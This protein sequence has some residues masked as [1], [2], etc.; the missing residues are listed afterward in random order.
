MN[1]DTFEGK[2]GQAMGLQGLTLRG[3]CRA[4]D[5]DPS[6][7]SKVLAGKRSPPWDEAVLRRLA[8]VLQ[9]D[10]VELI[11]STGRL[12][13]EWRV[14]LGNPRILSQARRLLRDDI[15]EELL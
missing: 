7:F 13:S 9:L 3:L 8:E 14:L 6:F 10:P 15:G 2:V 5:L 4:A 1:A 12:P 11:L